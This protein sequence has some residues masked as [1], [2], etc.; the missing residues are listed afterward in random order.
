MSVPGT[1]SHGKRGRSAPARR[2]ESGWTVLSSMLLNCE[3]A[4]RRT[5]CS[6]PPG[7]RQA[8][9]RKGAASGTAMAFALTASQQV[10]SW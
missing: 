1:A 9:G 3:V 6:V 8:R 2:S 5:R 7:G 4:V 10:W